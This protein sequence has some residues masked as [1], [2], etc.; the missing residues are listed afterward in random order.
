M[1]APKSAKTCYFCG[2]PIKDGVQYLTFARKITEW[3]WE[4]HAKEL[5]G[6]AG[7]PALC[8]ECNERLRQTV[9]SMRSI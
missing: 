4:Y 1:D 9:E 3:E 2:K 5:G 7:N 8:K 6:K